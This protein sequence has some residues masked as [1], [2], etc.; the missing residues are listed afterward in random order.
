MRIAHDLA[1]FLDHP[2][3]LIL[4]VFLIVV[5]KEALIALGL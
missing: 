2:G 3:L 5:L 1:V 4:L